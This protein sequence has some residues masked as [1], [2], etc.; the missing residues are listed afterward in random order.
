MKKLICLVLCAG[1]LLALCAC[2][3]K[4][5]QPAQ[6]TPTTDSP[7]SETSVPET[8]APA[9]PEVTEWTREGYFTDEM[10]RPRKPRELS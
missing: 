8:P 1:M 7:A 10:G 4:T 2:G 5:Q 9:E 6:E 3:A